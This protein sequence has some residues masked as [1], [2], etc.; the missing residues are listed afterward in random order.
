MWYVIQTLGNVDVQKVCDKFKQAMPDTLLKDVFVPQ[1]VCLKHYQKEWHEKLVPLFPNYF[2]VDTER[3]EEIRERLKVLSQIMKPV[4]VGEEFVPIY[5]E[6]QE[7]L[8]RMMDAGH[9]ICKS[10]GNIIDGRFD[11]YE[12]PLQDKAHLV[13]KVDRHR[14]L[15]YVEIQLHGERRQMQ[16][17]LEIIK[18]IVTQ[19]AV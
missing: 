6:E 18:K 3:A 13:R 2:F 14:R 10:V 16:V 1:Y 19:K 7:F 11:I 9:I 17:G 12:G 8:E 5:A 4:C 15:A